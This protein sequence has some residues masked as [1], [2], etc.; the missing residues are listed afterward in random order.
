M[1]VIDAS[2]LA[3][4]L[5][6]DGAVGDRARN[7]LSSDSGWA[8]PSHLFVE[9]LSVLRKKA[10]TGSLSPQRAADVLGA[11]G[12][13]AVE[14]I[15]T[16]DLVERIWELRANVSAYDAAYVAAAERLGCPLVTG[17]GRLAKAPGVRCATL[18]VD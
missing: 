11:L 14:E 16:I 4:A 2:A 15:P 6:D 3:D 12:E 13:I 18:V 1:I 5:M 17:D 8:A 9:V 10:R 7:L